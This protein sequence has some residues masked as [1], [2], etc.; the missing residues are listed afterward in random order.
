MQKIQLKQVSDPGLYFLFTGF[1][2]ILIIMG[3]YYTLSW[4]NKASVLRHAD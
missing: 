3:T 2:L 4:R 1:G